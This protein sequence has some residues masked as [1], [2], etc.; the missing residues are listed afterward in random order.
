MGLCN[1]GLSRNRDYIFENSREE[2]E[3]MK[4][5]NNLIVLSCFGL[6]GFFLQRLDLVWA[7]IMFGCGMLNLIE[8]KM[9]KQ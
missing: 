4:F 7:G 2:R 1:L 6:C 3:E 8:I 5:L 9:R